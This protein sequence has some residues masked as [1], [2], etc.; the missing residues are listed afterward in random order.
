MVR[1][2]SPG[3]QSPP[4]SGREEVH[5]P[6]LGGATSPEFDSLL[7]GRSSRQDSRQPGGARIPAGG[8]PK[9]DAP[10]KEYPDYSKQNDG[11][12]ATYRKD[13]F[14][15]PTSLEKRKEA[16]TRLD[17]RWGL[18]D[19][20]DLMQICEMGFSKSMRNLGKDILDDVHLEVETKM[21]QLGKEMSETVGS[22]ADS[23]QAMVGGLLSTILERVDSLQSTAMQQSDSTTLDFTPLLAEIRNSVSYNSQVQHDLAQKLDK[24]LDDR[25]T[26]VLD[27]IKAVGKRQENIEENVLPELRAEITMR[28]RGGA[29]VAD[30]VRQSD[31]ALSKVV[32]LT[33]ALS[34]DCRLTRQE[35]GQMLSDFT[36]H[37]GSDEKMGAFESKLEELLKKT[38][39]DQCVNVDWSEVQQSIDDAH[40]AD[41]TEM[42][43][44]RQEIARIQQAMNMD[45]ASVLENHLETTRAT[46]A[47]QQQ[48][49]SEDAR[50][51]V[52]AGSKSRK[53]VREYWAQTDS[54]STAEVSIQT[55]HYL[56]EKKANKKKPISKLGGTA[57]HQAA[58]KQS[59]AVFPDA[60]RLKEK[61]RKAMIKPQYNVF[62]DYHEEGW[63]RA[64]ATSGI[65]E[66]TTFAV[67]FFNAIW[68]A[69]DLDWN[70][71]DVLVDADFIFQLAEHTFRLYFSFELA[72][73]FMAFSRKRTVLTN[74]WF[75]FD[76][77]LL[78]LMI[79]ET[80]II[81]A[82]LLATDARSSTSLR[83]ATI[84][85]S[86]R[87]VKMLRISRMARI[88]R[89]IPELVILV[90]GIG[91]AARSVSVFCL[92]WLVILYVFAIFLRQ[93]TADTPSVGEIYF[94]SV[95]HGMN[96]LLLDIILPDGAQV[97]ND[98]S[99]EAWH[100]YPV[101]LVFIM[102]ASVTTMYMLIG[103]LCEVISA[104]ASTEKESLVVGRVAEHLRD[105]L[106]SHGRDPDG[107]FSKK[108]FQDLLVEEDVMRILFDVGVE[109][110]ILLDASDVI[111][112][113]LDRDGEGLEF[114]KFVECVLSMRG[115]STATV[116]DVTQ[117]LI[118][119]KTMM[120]DNTTKL[121]VKIKEEVNFLHA[122][123]LESKVQDVHVDEPDEHD[124]DAERM[125]AQSAAFAAN[126]W[127]KATSAAV[128]KT[129]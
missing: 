7:S 114:E 127:I 35:V 110:S 129:P 9:H 2:R 92:F 32:S 88:L 33:Q 113:R 64:I 60:Q 104:I 112:E 91:A 82:V 14:G 24:S 27:E 51:K 123:L 122:A 46:V 66:N 70:E 65:F 10:F 39:Q 21:Q 86:V 53:R 87:L 116:H 37:I 56:M 125:E 101:M 45:F 23:N 76:T 128:A 89:V 84:L 96:T 108:E 67:I 18:G 74:F 103:V 90:K 22:L 62:D 72:V 119:M 78:F 4:R 52:L 3:E 71:A 8:P 16:P 38:T 15:T 98:V 6:R 50:L 120:K 31:A 109:A 19:T 57:T 44:L 124:E 118:L 79:M 100:L 93:A 63:A 5:T 97:V 26:E 29:D 40:D 1:T 43:V 48:Q 75:V 94:Q 28:A 49:V 13:T 99:D 68:I 12:H 102:L 11:Q 126:T 69:V 36:K 80:W 47:E 121:E 41:M 73:R 55:P 77:A 85:K 34:V 42:R 115:S 58:R 111:F 20:R 107:S 95:P 17:K 81:T 54:P 105:A 61:A 30:V 59:V 25:M 106:I 83:E 117:L